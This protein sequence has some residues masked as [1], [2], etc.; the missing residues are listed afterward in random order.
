MAPL[1]PVFWLLLLLLLGARPALA[2]SAPFD[3][4]G[5]TLRVSVTHDAVTLPIAQAP[6]LSPGDHVSIRADLPPGQSAHYLLV[7][8]FLRGA[9]NPPP[10]NWFYQSQTWNPKAANGLSLTV[11]PGAQHMILFLAPETGGDFKTLVGAVRGRPGAFVR[12][13]QDLNQATLDRSRLAAFLAAIRRINQSD[14]EQLKAVSN[15]LARGLAIKL[16]SECFQKAPE[17]QASCLMQ[18]QD[19]LVLSDGHSTSIVEALTS[20]AAADLAV[21]LSTTPAA[22]YGAYSPYVGAVL[23]IAR[24]MESFHTARYQYIPALTT[25][26]GDALSLLLNT[27]P[28]FHDP[29]SVLVVALPAVEPPQPPPLQT[30]GSKTAYCAERPGLV[31][32]VEGAP[33]VFSTA[34]THDMVL[35]LKSADG[36]PIDLPVRADAEKGGLVVDAGGLDAGRLGATL[37]GTLH[38]YWGFEPFEGPAFHL[39]TARAEPWRLAADDQSSLIAGRDDTV[40]LQGPDAACIESIMLRQASGDIQ[41]VE[42][43]AT[44]PD[45]LT[46]TVPL[47]SAQPGAVTLLV[48]Q[49]GA[50]DA[51]PI[52]LRAFAQAGHL[53]SFTLHAGDLSGMLKGARLDEVAGLTLRGAAFAPGHLITSGGAD[54]LSLTTAD[55]GAVAGLKAGDSANAKVSLKDGR[56]VNLKVA[57]APIRPGVALIGKSVR[58]DTPGMIQLTNKDEAP[59]GAILTFSLHALAPTLFSDHDKVEVAAGDGAVLATLTPAE[60]LILEDAQVAVATLDTGKAFSASAFGPLRFRLVDDGVEGEWQP[61]A[62]LVRLPLIRDLKCRAGAGQPCDLTGSNLFLIDSL[63]S[64]PAFDHP[65]TVQEG[66]PGDVLRVPHPVAGRL[67]L[68]LRDDPAVVNRLGSPSAEPTAAPDDHAPT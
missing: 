43:K 38:G 21:Q 39:Q 17:L 63:S 50:K 12:A 14:P 40:R 64:G 27:P 15:L 48:K 7:A 32:A 49:Y 54:E 34:Y 62:A 26:R 2:D 61:L 55:T 28:S 36:A 9:T 5:P 42:W 8:A 37:D 16:D 47:K 13:S 35:R 24:I 30:V 10:A 20:G 23:D 4:T 33:L 44:Q 46:V 25:V 22:G 59:R 18:G 65:V 45:E 31:L 3:L 68:K 29:L 66:F 51:E 11:P 6:N 41:T 53:D 56:T 52:P 67:Y 58:W 57:I 60:G 1:S 19:S